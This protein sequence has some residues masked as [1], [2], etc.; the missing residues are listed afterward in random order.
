MAD[1]NWSSPVRKFTDDLKIINV[2]CRQEES[3][4]FVTFKSELQMN[5]LSCLIYCFNLH[6]T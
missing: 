5:F 6:L 4:R 1:C 2:A 3:V